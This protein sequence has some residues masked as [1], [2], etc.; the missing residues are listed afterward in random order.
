MISLNLESIISYGFKVMAIVQQPEFVNI[1][2][3]CLL[4]ER[5]A[6]REHLDEDTLRKT[7]NPSVWDSN[8]GNYIKQGIRLSYPNLFIDLLDQAYQS[9]GEPIS[10]RE[11]SEKIA[12]ALQSFVNPFPKGEELVCPHFLLHG[13]T[14]KRSSD[15]VVK[16]IEKNSDI[17]HQTLSIREQVQQDLF[18]HDC[19][20]GYKIFAANGQ[21]EDLFGTASVLV[22]ANSRF[23]E[24]VDSWFISKVASLS[25]L[26][27]RRC[28]S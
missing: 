12:V 10:A 17:I 21:V 20:N 25:I 8:R 13:L 14:N 24:F 2:E 11:F 26:S 18:P 27:G 3:H 28:T 19:R 23:F 7:L 5:E 16:Q 9:L 1:L 6:Y 4:P 15:Q 22:Q